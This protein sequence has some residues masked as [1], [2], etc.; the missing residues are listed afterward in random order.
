MI[1]AAPMDEVELRNMMY[2]AAEKQNGPFSI[3]YPR[4]TGT[5]VNWRQPFKAIQIGQGRKLKSGDDIAILSIGAIGS[6]AT[7]AIETLETRGI[8]AAHYD[9]RFVK[10][11]DE[12]MLH[13][14]FGKFNA[15]I[16]IEDGCLMGG[17]GSAVTE[18]MGD[19]GYQAHVKRLGLGDHYVEH[20]TQAQLYAENGYDAA[21]VVANAEE[22]V[23]VSKSTN[24]TTKSA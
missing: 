24:R 16:T 21:A 7:E 9:M 6:Q 10:P 1:V 8:S 3:R 23:S 17:F 14:I 11:L 12:T 19:N 20:G 5:I 13:E 18:F 4:G 15:V 22:L 2:T